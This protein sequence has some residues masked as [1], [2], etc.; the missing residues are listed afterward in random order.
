M[1][2]TFSLKENSTCRL[3]HLLPSMLNLNFLFHSRASSKTIGGT[4][5]GVNIMEVVSWEFLDNKPTEQRTN[6]RLFFFMFSQLKTYL[7]Q[8]KR[9]TMGKSCAL[10]GM[11]R[12]CITKTRLF[13]NMEN[14]TSKKTENF[15]MKNSGIFHISAQNIGCGYSLEPPRRGGS[16][17]YPQ[18]MF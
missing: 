8:L 5:R 7:T 9:R 18:P 2:N 16:N 10:S 6:T 11:E 4:E 14:F 17:E 3:L 1:S 15:Q 12:T 13:K